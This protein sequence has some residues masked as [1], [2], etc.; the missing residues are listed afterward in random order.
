M[1]EKEA[2]FFLFFLFIIWKGFKKT[3]KIEGGI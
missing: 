3:R 1:K 2:A